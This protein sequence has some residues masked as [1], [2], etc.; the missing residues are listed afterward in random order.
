MMF[1][2]LWYSY[3]LKEF[4]RL[5][6]IIEQQTKMCSCKDHY[7]TSPLPVKR[8]NLTRYVKRKSKQK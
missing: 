6:K 7:L 8:Q 1:I 4:E 2:S 5:D 3:M